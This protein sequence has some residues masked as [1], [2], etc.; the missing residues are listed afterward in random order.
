M[1]GCGF[2]EDVEDETFIQI[3][4]LHDNIGVKMDVVFKLKFEAIGA[5]DHQVDSL[6][7]S[8]I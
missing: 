2:I 7:D 6:T 1:K 4:Y 5:L 3:Y 8:S